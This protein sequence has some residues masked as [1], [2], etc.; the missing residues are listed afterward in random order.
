MVSANGYFVGTFDFSSSNQFCTTSMLGFV[1]SAP[2]PSLII[3][4][5]WPSGDTSY[6]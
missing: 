5:R 1:W 4:N 2:L 6:V 3:R